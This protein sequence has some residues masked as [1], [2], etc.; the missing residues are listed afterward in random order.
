MLTLLFPFKR[1]AVTNIVLQNEKSLAE[2]MKIAKSL[3]FHIEKPK[4]Y[5]LIILLTY[6]L[7]YITLY[8]FNISY[9]L[10]M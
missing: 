5:I 8:L 6:I 10:R 2:P 4:N 9:N 1:H 3:C 7:T